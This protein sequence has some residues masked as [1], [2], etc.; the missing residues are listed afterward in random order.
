MI[1]GIL[2]IGLIKQKAQ[3]INDGIDIQDGLPIFSQN[4]ETDL[5]IEINVGM[6]NFGIAFHLWGRMRIMRWNGK[7]KVVGSV[8]PVASVGSNND[9]KGRQVIGIGEFDFHHLAAVQ[10]RNVCDNDTNDNDDTNVSEC[11]IRMKISTIPDLRLLS[12]GA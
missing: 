6:I 11:K 12:S 9:V 3:S 5:A 4:V 7:S 1:E 2:W 10:F 8:S